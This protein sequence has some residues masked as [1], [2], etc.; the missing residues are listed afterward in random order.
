LTGL[1]KLIRWVAGIGGVL[2]ILYVAFRFLR[3]MH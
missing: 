1:L 3:L 2:L